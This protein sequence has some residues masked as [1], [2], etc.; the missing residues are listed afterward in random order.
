MKKDFLKRKEVKAK[1]GELEVFNPNTKQRKEMQKDVSQL[2]TEM[3][4]SFSRELKNSGYQ[5]NEKVE[6]DLI[7]KVLKTTIEKE[8]SKSEFLMKKYI[9]MLTNIP[10]EILD[11]EELFN[12]I[13]EDP[14]DEL[15]YAMKD[16]NEMMSEYVEDY[17]KLFEKNLSKT[18]KK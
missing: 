15:R 17:Q 3:I 5:D 13:I 14:S 4:T 16:I 1:Y 2:N 9:K 8:T 7:N 18:M 12:E 10:E 11:D 6:Q